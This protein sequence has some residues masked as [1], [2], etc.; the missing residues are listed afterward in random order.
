MVCIVLTEQAL[1]PYIANPTPPGPY[2]IFAP[3]PDDETFGM[4]GTLSLSIGRGIPVTVVILTDGS[5]GGD[6]ETRKAEALCAMRCLGVTDIRFC[7]WTDRD[8][9][10]RKQVSH[11]CG[12]FIQDIAPRT[13]FFPS[14]LEFHPDHRATALWV[15]QAIQKLGFDGHAM[16]YEITRQGECN[17]LIDITSVFEQKEK[18]IGCYS[19]Q[20]EQRDYRDIAIALN[21]LRSYTLSSEC[22]YAEA[23]F[24][25]PEPGK[26]TL[27]NVHQRL[28]E[29]YFVC[30][31]EQTEFSA[32]DP[33]SGI[34][35]NLG[36]PPEKT[37]PKKEE[38]ASHNYNIRSPVQR[39]PLVSIIVR[40]KDRPSLVERALRSIASQTYGHIEVIL[41][42]DGGCDLP[43][44]KFRSM[45]GKAKLNYIG[46]S[47]NAGRAQAGNIGITQ[48]KGDYIGFL[49]DDDEFYPDHIYE[50]VSCIDRSDFKAVYSAVEFVENAFSKDDSRKETH[51]KH[52]FGQPFSLDELLIANYIPLIS[53]LF[54]ARHL[55]NLNFDESFELYEDW[56]LLIRAGGMAELH[57]VNSITARYNQWDSSQIAFQSSPEIIKNATLKIYAKHRDKMPLEKVFTMREDAY[58]KDLHINSMETK[59]SKLTNELAKKDALIAEIYSGKGWK[60]LT[61]YWKIKGFFR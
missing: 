40:T 35:S 53:L 10:N 46:L 23:F 17:R 48:A 43:E 27:Q 55:K 42:N 38:N 49:D 2:L 8:I 37:D 56:D 11:V 9:S 41:V 21:R 34:H 28:L 57:F 58:N 22:K 30:K 39:D 1:I 29:N 6:P 18:A 33:M 7:R 36:I 4:G 44:E 12:Q 26:R 14:P 20:L 31:H 51:V 61:Y 5:A 60:L 52:V 3:H 25:Y 19:S 59:L 16:H 45:L 47:Q 54:E 32:T 50:L 15:W 13:I 24:E